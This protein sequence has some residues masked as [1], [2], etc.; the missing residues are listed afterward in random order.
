[1]RQDFVAQFIQLLK[2]WLCAVRWGIVVEKNWGLAVDQCWLQM[3]QFLVHLLNLQS[4]LVDGMVLP[5]FR[6][7]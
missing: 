5:G 6:K 2:C 4:I 1:M 3:W 7:L